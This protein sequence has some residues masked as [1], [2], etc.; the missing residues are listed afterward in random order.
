MNVEGEIVLP[1]QGVETRK[2]P[3]LGRF[4]CL[5]QDDTRLMN[6]TITRGTENAPNVE[7]PWNLIRQRWASE[8][9]MKPLLSDFTELSL[10]VFRIV[11]CQKIDVPLIMRWT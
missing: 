9:G 5:H 2:I 1:L 11:R 3:S 6:I 8:R 7:L 10:S 4:K